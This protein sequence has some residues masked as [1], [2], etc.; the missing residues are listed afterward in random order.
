MVRGRLRVH[1]DELEVTTLG[2]GSTVGELA[3]LIPEPRSASVTAIEP[4]TLLRID[5]PV[6][7]EL[8]ADRPALASGIIAALVGMVRE[9]VRVHT[10][11]TSA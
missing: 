4:A 6:L 10:D 8:L 11:S 5:K 2:P 1:H 9:R 3:A 7:D